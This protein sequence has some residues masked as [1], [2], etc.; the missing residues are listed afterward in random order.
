MTV[1]TEGKVKQVAADKLAKLELRINVGSTAKNGDPVTFTVHKVSDDSQLDTVDGT[2]T[3]GKAVGDWKAKGPD[4]TGPD[5]SWRVYYKV[6]IGVEE[7]VSPELDVYL[8][9]LELTSQDE[10]GGSLADAGFTVYVGKKDLKGKKATTG[11]SGT[12]K[13][14]GLPPGEPVRVEWKAPLRQLGDWVEDGAGKKTAKLKKSFKAKL[15]FP[16][17]GDHTQWINHK[18]DKKTPEHGSK[19]RVRARCVD[20]DGPTRKG[21]VFYVKVTWPDAATLS[22]RTSPRRALEGGKKTDWSGDGF[23]KK[24]TIKKDGDD[25]VFEVQLGMAGG[26]TVTI[27]VGGTDTVDDGAKVEVKN[28]RKLYYQIT[29]NKAAAA[30]PDMT[31]MAAALAKVGVVYEKYGDATYEE[32]EDKLPGGAFFDGAEVGRAGER[33]V[34]IGDHNK[35]WFHT[36]KFKDTKK[37]LGVHVLLCDIQLDAGS[38][39]PMVE[40]MSG[41]LDAP[42][43]TLRCKKGIPFKTALFDG[44]AGIT[45]ATWK[46]LAPKKHADHGK[47]GALSLAD[48]V[49]NPFTKDIK[50]VLPSP[51]KDIVGN[52]SGA[53]HKVQVRFKVKVAAGWFLGEADGDHG[54]WQL[55]ALQKRASTNDKV[56]SRVDTE[57]CK[58]MT[59]ELGHTMKQTVRKSTQPPGL[60]AADHKRTYTAHGHQGPHCADGMSQ[61]DYDSLESFKGQAACT[62]VMYGEGRTTVLI[63][64]CARCKPYVVAERLEK[65]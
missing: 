27:E 45:S 48:F 64:F 51:A 17:A 32:G 23:G 16:E 29:K 14:T 19:L 37:P 35:K 58:T 39:S 26:D 21:D 49:V 41:D 55:I 13:M 15:V 56:E 47:K 65:L 28:D 62:C 5:R 60:S 30:A 50:V 2:I 18:A 31:T 8:D 3:K 54:N 22:K 43:A 4:P 1:A 25:C 9:T 42:S 20:E 10:D 34:C 7:A 59:H 52:G 6:T 61:T 53:K 40:A 36:K 24:V 38:P 12:F 11:S 33:L 57:V 46:S 44:K 63:D